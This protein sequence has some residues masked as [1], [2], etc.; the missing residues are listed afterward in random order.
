MQILLFLIL[1]VPSSLLNDSSILINKFSKNLNK[2]ELKCLV[3]NAFYEAG[4]Q[5]DIGMLLVTNVVFNRA[6]LTN[7]SHCNTIYK[8]KQ[9]SWTTSKKLVKIPYNIRIEIENLVLGFSGGALDHKIP[10]HLKHALF[11][12]ADYVDPKWF[13]TRKHLGIWG[14]HIFYL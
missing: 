7:E 13:K 14:N 9:F 12:H 8:K 1:L 11:Y 2:V 4:N 5:G 6:K 3:D 10:K